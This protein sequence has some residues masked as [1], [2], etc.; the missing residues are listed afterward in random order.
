MKQDYFALLIAKF[1]VNPRLGIAGGVVI[2]IG[3][4]QNPAMPRNRQDVPGAVQFFRRSCLESIGS[5]IPVPEGGWD[6]LTCAKARMVGYET[7]LFCDL[8]VDHLKPR[9]SAIKGSLIRKWYMGRRDYALGYG[10]AF[11]VLKY[12]SRTLE[13]PRL[14]GSIAWLGGCFSSMLLRRRRLVPREL[15]AFVRQEQSERV[16]ELL[17]GWFTPRNS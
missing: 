2:D 11:E 6:A 16:L 10:A 9:N 1:R 8:Q 13:P 7:A 14:S 17:R 5:L 15:L 4:G 12:V 3:S